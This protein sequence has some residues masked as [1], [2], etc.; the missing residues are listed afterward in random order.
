ML[1][2]NVLLVGVVRPLLSIMMLP[3]PPETVRFF[4]A[5]SEIPKVL[6]LFTIADVILPGTS[7]PPFTS[8][9]LTEFRVTPAT[10]AE[11]VAFAA[12]VTDTAFVSA[13]P[14]MSTVPLVFVVL[15]LLD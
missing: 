15:T 3:L 4:K 1:R 10:V 11:A 8:A 14:V 7:M 12:L 2:A 13:E 5:L 9:I 6:K